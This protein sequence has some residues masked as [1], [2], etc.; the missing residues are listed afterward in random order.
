MNRQ[1]GWITVSSLVCSL[2][3]AGCSSGPDLGVRSS[4]YEDW[5]EDIGRSGYVPVLPF[6]E[7]VRVGDMYLYQNDPEVS[8]FFGSSAPSLNSGG[9]TMRWGSIDVADMLSD[10]YG[11][12]QRF[13]ETPARDDAW[14]GEADSNLRDVAVSAASAI[15]V[16]GVE[17]GGLIPTEAADLAPGTNWEDAEAITV[18]LSETESYGLPLSRLLGEI[19]ESRDDGPYLRAPYGE[20]IG[21]L[22]TGTR[23]RVFLRVVGEVAYVRA[24]DIAIKLDSEA[25]RKRAERMYERDLY[26]R[27][28]AQALA[29]Q[30]R[31]EQRER[32]REVI[33]A[34][35]Q[36]RERAEREAAE[37]G[38]TIPPEDM[39]TTGVLMDETPPPPVRLT[40]EEMAAAREEEIAASVRPFAR[41]ERINT[42]LRENDVARPI[43]NTVQFLS[44]SDD[45]V[46]MRKYFRHGLAF[47]VRGITLEVEASTGKVLRLTPMGE[48]FRQRPVTGE[49]EEDADASGGGT[50]SERADS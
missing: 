7:D 8:N 41:A 19:I 42:E 15:T 28:Q 33:E 21:L 48:D 32:A 24:A 2:G 22:A 6:Q 18:R 45:S 9:G 13:T 5:N 16:S 29:E 46:A 4:F 3:L 14:M 37:R 39:D 1:L 17:A 26:E 23:D 49:D 31:A 38:E 30:Q 10:E 11:R 36:A 40:A 20:D 27:Q 34:R 44:M 25:V 50:T 47:A 35:R 12:R 43:N